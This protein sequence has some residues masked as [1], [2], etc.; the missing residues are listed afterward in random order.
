MNSNWE[1]LGLVL[2]EA[3]YFK[4]PIIAPRISAIPEVIINNYNGYLVKPNNVRSYSLAMSKIID[5]K[6][7]K[8]FSK[9]SKIVLNENFDY[10][11]MVTKIKKIYLT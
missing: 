3:M 10:I 4:K 1:G 5:K 6:I 2:L 8:K 7:G 9:N 11:K